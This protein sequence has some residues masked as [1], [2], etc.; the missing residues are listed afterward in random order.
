M[1]TLILS[2]LILFA[3]SAWGGDWVVIVHPNS[4]VAQLSKGEVINIFMGRYRK[5]PSGQ[6]AIPLDVIYPVSGREHFYRDL[7]N[8]E[9]AEVDSYWARLKF[10][11]QVSPPLVVESSDEAI[12]MVASNI[13][14][15]AY[16]DKAKVTDKVKVVFDFNR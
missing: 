5:F 12:K 3:H 7:L 10:S 9:L 2:I 8:K 13:N 6:S 16:C 11:G 4:G 14:Y 15:I 1:K